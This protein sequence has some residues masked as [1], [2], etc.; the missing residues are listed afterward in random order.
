MKP[1]QIPG[2]TACA[3]A[4]PTSDLL[5]RNVNEPTIAELAVNKTE[6]ITTYRMFGSLNEKK[7]TSEFILSSIKSKKS[8]HTKS[9]KNRKVFTKKFLVL[10]L[11]SDSF[12]SISAF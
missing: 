2:N 4:S 9:T 12:F 3:M 5:F 6:P 10:F 7:S 1:K 11:I 8:N